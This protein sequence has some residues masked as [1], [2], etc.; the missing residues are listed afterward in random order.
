MK[1]IFQ[2]QMGNTALFVLGMLGVMMVLF[3]LVMNLGSVLAV[4]EKSET[5]ASQA[6]LAASSIVYEN[7]QKIIKDYG[8]SLIKPVPPTD[9]DDT[10]AW[11]QYYEDLKVYV[12]FTT[13]IADQ[14]NGNFYVQLNERVN[15]FSGNASF[16]GWSSNEKHLEALDEIIDGILRGSGIVKDTLYHLL[17]GNVEE[18]AICTAINTI[19]NEKN[20]G[21]I[22]GAEFEIINNQI[23]I[24]SSNKLKAISYNSLLE[25]VEDKVFQESAGPVINFL[26][27]IWVGSKFEKLDQYYCPN[28]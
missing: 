15:Q 10:A 21:V 27:T 7:V 19:E 13:N 17:L 1:N 11:E 22:E 23:Y 14:T 9:P 8:D 3:V 5:T 2:N 16:N 4:K 26:E 6:S 20:N 24:R 18:E 28:S 12:F 25:N